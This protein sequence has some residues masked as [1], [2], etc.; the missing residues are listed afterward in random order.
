MR[1]KTGKE[2][3]RERKDREREGGE[4]VRKKTCRERERWGGEK[5]DGQRESET[6]REISGVTNHFLFIIINDGTGT[7]IFLTK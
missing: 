1:K 6:E 7:S 4:G 5:K 2:R 3:G